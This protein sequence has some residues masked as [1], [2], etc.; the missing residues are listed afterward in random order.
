MVNILPASR[1][2]RVSV[3]RQTG[4]Q[5]IKGFGTL[6]I[7]TGDAAKAGASASAPSA[8]NKTKAYTQIDDV[9]SDYAATSE[10]YLAAAAAFGRNPSPSTVKIG[11]RDIANPIA[12]EIQA[13]RSA[14]PDWYW[15][16]FT[17]EVRDNVADATA[18]ATYVETIKAICLLDTNDVATE[19]GTDTACVAA[20]LKA[21]GYDRTGV[22]YMPTATEGY[23]S[24]AA[25]A[26]GATRNFDSP[27]SAYTAKFKSFPGLTPIN[28]EAATV[29]AITGWAG[30]DSGFVETAGHYANTYVNVGGQ[31]IFV[32]GNTAKP[33]FIDTIHFA[34]WLE[35]RMTEAVYGLLKFKARVAYDAR[36]VEEVA[37]KMQGV[38]ERA[39]ASGAIAADIDEDGNSLDAYTITRPNVLTVSDAQRSQRIS[40]TFKFCARYAGAFHSVLINGDLEV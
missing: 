5:Q 32:E 27:D 2:V 13:I 21:A 22:C 25:M 15:L 29:S 1:I 40:P 4:V 16:G 7:V 12:D 37:S 20:V 24:I 6:L 18:I 35:Q 26:Y 19:T 14:D 23:L 33:E 3:N 10:P 31:D 36:G 9:L 28:K 38:M 17:K 8:T 11:F 39:V 30:P 34:D